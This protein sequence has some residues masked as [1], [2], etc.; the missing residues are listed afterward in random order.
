MD[1]I[2]ARVFLGLWLLPVLVLAAL[3]PRCFRGAFTDA[4]DI[5]V[6]EP[7]AAVRDARAL[8]AQH[9]QYRDQVSPEQ[10][11]PSLR[12]RNLR[13]AHVHEDRVCLIIA[14]NPD[15]SIGARIWSERPRPHHDQRTRYPDIHFYRYTNDAPVSIDNIP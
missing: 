1:R 7:A 14:R 9:A 12:I 8:M 6:A 10:L 2:A 4:D 5:V 11:P 13:W 3:V 15:V